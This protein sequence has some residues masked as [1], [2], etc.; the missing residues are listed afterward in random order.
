MKTT[1][2]NMTN[3]T[4]S[5]HNYEMTITLV[6]GENTYV[7]IYTQ[8]YN[9]TSNKRTRKFFKNGK[10]QTKHERFQV[11]EFMNDNISECLTVSK[12]WKTK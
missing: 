10:V 2:N 7:E 11:E 9:A 5:T 3:S 12:E 8:K 1:K 4:T 6:A